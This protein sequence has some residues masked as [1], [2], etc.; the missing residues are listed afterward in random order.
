M[1]VVIGVAPT[2]AEIRLRPHELFAR[3]AT[4]HFSYIRSFEFARAVA[5]SPTSS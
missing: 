1:I 2:A 3:E 5:C 4:I